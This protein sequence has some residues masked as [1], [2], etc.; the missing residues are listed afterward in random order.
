MGALVAR[1]IVIVALL[2]SAVLLNVTSGDLSEIV[3]YLHN[4]TSL[5]GLL[6]LIVLA[7]TVLFT[8]IDCERSI[9]HVVI[10]NVEAEVNERFSLREEDPKPPEKSIKKN[11]QRSTVVSERTEQLNDRTQVCTRQEWEELYMPRLSNTLSKTSTCS[12]CLSSISMDSKVRGLACGHIFHLACVA[13]WFM[14]D[15]TFEL[16]CPLCRVPL[17][18]QRSMSTLQRA[19]DDDGEGNESSQSESST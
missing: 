11:F 10:P 2:A 8:S 1:S 17:R 14:K 15:R 19:S 3:H 7:L 16:C 4:L 12:I 5:A 13:E 18:D 6:S 9:R